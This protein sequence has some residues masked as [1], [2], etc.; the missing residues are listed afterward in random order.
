[1]TAFADR[2]L[3][4]YRQYGRHDLPWQ[5]E[6]SLYRTWVSEVMLQQTQVA[7]VIPYFE[8]FMQRFPDISTLAEASQDEVMRYWA[9][10]GLLQ[11][12][13]EPA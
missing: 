10:L 3:D 13:Q 8:K 12:G 6:S 4:W 5:V 11:P 7:T 9:G 2:L 1:M